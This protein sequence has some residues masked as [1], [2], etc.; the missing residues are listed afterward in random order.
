MTHPDPEQRPKIKQVKELLLWIREENPEPKL[1]AEILK[2]NRGIDPFFYGVSLAEQM[3]SE[4]ESV[5]EELCKII[6]YCLS[7]IYTKSDMQTFYNGFMETL[8]DEFLEEAKTIRSRIETLLKEKQ[9][10]IPMRE[11]SKKDIA[12]LNQRLYIVPVDL[13]TELLGLRE[14]TWTFCSDINEDLWIVIVKMGEIRFVDFDFR[15][16][17]KPVIHLDDL[18]NVLKEE[19]IDPFCFVPKSFAKEIS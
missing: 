7:A 17:E 13:A 9:G 2:I 10:T 8:S 19:N 5:E 15:G 11:I 18:L 3:K 16:D 4:E 14:G 12:H 1:V 6:D